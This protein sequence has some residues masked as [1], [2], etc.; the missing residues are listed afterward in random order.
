MTTCSSER[1]W[2]S[3]LLLAVI[4]LA[5]LVIS[6]GGQTPSEGG[7]AAEYPADMGIGNDPNVI[8]FTDFEPDEWHKHWLGG[9]RETVS[10]VAEDK[11]RGFQS[12]KNK[13]LQIKVRKGEHYG[14]S[15]QYKFKEKNRERARR[16]LLPL[17]PSFRE[18]LGSQ[19]GRQA[20]VRE[21]GHT[22][23]R[24]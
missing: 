11:K 7:L 9:K 17:L 3:A 16:N 5:P 21:G 13:A 18:R 19:K 20:R 12:L 1:V 6:P 23:A 8:V 10:V 15:I 24:C 22:H 2:T 4:C 14:A